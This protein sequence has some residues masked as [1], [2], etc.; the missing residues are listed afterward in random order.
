M[1]VQDLQGTS[2]RAKVQINDSRIHDDSCSFVVQVAHY[3]LIMPFLWHFRPYW[4]GDTLFFL[5]SF[6]SFLG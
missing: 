6:L 4:Y 3:R 1:K 5:R 2:E